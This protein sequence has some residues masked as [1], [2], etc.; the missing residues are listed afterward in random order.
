[1][2][3]YWNVLNRPRPRSSRGEQFLRFSKNDLTWFNRNFLLFDARKS[4]VFQIFLLRSIWF[5]GQ[6]WT[7]AD[8]IRKMVI[9]IKRYIAYRVYRSFKLTQTA[10]NFI[11]EHAISFLSD[12]KA[13]LI[14]KQF[15]YVRA[16]WNICNQ[17]KKSRLVNVLR[18]LEFVFREPNLYFM[19]SI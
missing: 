16:I 4:C 1:M 3:S 12:Q 15:V 8:Q 13:A 7:L 19:H 10:R 17:F 9:Q 5:P 6:F 11:L 2:N 14:G 18:A